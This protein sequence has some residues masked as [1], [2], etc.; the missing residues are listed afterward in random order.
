MLVG[1]RTSIYISKDDFE[2]KSLTES[3]SES[4]HEYVFGF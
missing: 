4:N 2:V 1:D 3:M